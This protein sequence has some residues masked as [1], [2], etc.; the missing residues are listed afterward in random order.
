MIRSRTFAALAACTL[1]VLPTAGCYQGFEGTVNTQ[2]PTG[3]GTDFEV[4]Q[5]LLVQDTTL[6]ADPDDPSTAALVMTVVNIGEVDDAVVSVANDQGA[7]GAS[8]GPVLV[9]SG[10]AAQVGGPGNPSI[11]LTGLA[12]GPGTFTTVTLSFERNGSVTTPVA[13]VPATG[14]YADYGPTADSAE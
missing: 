12:K 4:G 10:T 6:V 13:I 7:E 14:Y 1:A 8:E 2:D 5:D 11:V 9:P 3:N